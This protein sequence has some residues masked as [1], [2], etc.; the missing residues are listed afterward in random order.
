M[1]AI[2]GRYYVTPFKVHLGVT[3]GHP[4]TPT[5][6]NMVV[7]AVICHWVMLV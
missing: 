6:F 1:V 5:I 4:L 2:E 7:D 3:Q